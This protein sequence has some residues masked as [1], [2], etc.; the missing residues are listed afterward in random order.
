MANVE[1]L[2]FNNG[3][4]M[5]AIGYGTWRAPDEE[6]ERALNLALEA[7][8]RHIDCA[9]VYLNEKAIGKVLK[10]WIDA[11]KVKREDLFITTKLPDFGNRPESVEKNLKKS[12]ADLN[13]SYVDLYLMHTP[14]GFPEPTDGQLAFH[15]NGD[16]V[17]DLTTDHV[18]IWKKLEEFVGA[19]LIKSIGI[20]N[21]NQRQVQRILDN[22][23]IKPASLQIE[24]HVY[25]Q[26]NEL[27]EFCKANNIIVT[28]YSPLGSKGIAEFLS[29]I[30]G[31]QRN[32][33]DLLE[34]PEVKA[35]ATR[36]GKTPA[37]ILLKWIVKRGV[38]AIPKSTNAGRLRENLAL[39]DFDLTTEDMET[40]K[41]L[42]K[43][44]RICTFD[45]F[46]GV[47]KH[48]EFPF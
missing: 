4:K 40:I 1:F 37:Q 10:E 25:F 36:L 7:G 39:F 9:P 28:A 29:K 17:L 44:I 42:D 22:A 14:F 34:I 48:P 35:I 23:T 38:A 46:Q 27:V 20:S 26:Q 30:T 12:L 5:P 19:G 43:G 45:F 6:I 32:V 41:G 31:K 11:G 16:V 47:D 24:L 33:P 21:F 15:P 3:I 18:A 2:T 13:L 8:Y